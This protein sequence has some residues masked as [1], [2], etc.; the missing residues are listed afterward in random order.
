MFYVS[1]PDLC[2]LILVPLYMFY[3]MVNSANQRNLIP[4]KTKERALIKH[5]YWL[6]PLATLIII[7]C[8]SC[9]LNEL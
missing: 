3:V 9:Y 8:W 1:F 7:F 2:L 5:A 4:I 6:I